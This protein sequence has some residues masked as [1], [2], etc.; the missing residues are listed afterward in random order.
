MEALAKAA[1]AARPLTD[2]R[3]A[4]MKVVTVST[5]FATHYGYSCFMR[6][7]ESLVRLGLSHIAVEGRARTGAPTARPRA[8]GLVLRIG[9]TTA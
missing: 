5:T 7:K 8:V 4:S 1:V 6:K 3:A 9:V 2:T